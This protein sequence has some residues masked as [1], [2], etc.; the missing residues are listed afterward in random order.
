[1]GWDAIKQN[2]LTLSVFLIYNCQKKKKKG[3]NLKM[4]A[5]TCQ[6]NNNTDWQYFIIYLY[7]YIYI[8]IYI[9]EINHYKK[10]ILKQ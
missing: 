4:L 5:N 7:I 9:S 8:Y 6:N 10:A 3:N 1:M 2:N